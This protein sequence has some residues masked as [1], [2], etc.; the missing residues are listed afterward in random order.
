MIIVTKQA[1][2]GNKTGILL[3]PQLNYWENNSIMI[4]WSLKLQTFSESMPIYPYA[5][6]VTSNRKGI[7]LYAYISYVK[8]PK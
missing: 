7:T 4:H 1:K 2:F 3:C 8:S 5:A 6:Y